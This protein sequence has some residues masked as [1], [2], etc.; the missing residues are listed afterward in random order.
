MSYYK[1]TLE[2][3]FE[4]SFYRSL[5][6]PPVSDKYGADLIIRITLDDMSLLDSF[7]MALPIKV[8]CL[9]ISQVIK[10]YIVG[11]TV[12]ERN[13]L[14]NRLLIYP[15]P[16]LS[17]IQD[18][19]TDIFTAG[20]VNIQYHINNG[21]TNVQPDDPL[22]IHEQLQVTN[23]YIYKLI[24]IVLEVHYR[25]NLTESQKNVMLDDFRQVFILYAIDKFGY[26][27]DFENMN[28]QIAEMMLALL[29]KLS[30]DDFSLIQI[31]GDD[32]S[33]PTI[34]YKGYDLLDSIIDEAEFYIS[35]Y[36]I[37]GDVCIKGFK[38]ILFYTGYGDNLI[39]PVFIREGIDPYRAIFLSALYLGNMDEI[40]SNLNRLSSEEIFSE[41]FRLIAISQTEKDVSPEFL[42]MIIAEGKKKIS[43]QRLSEDWIRITE[44]I[45]QRMKL[46]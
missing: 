20:N 19:L 39:I 24:D 42:D 7:Y 34:F 45:K 32:W 21:E 17:D 46:L 30:S 3:S 2:E 14:K 41:L 11:E 44:N 29:K 35:N 18:I 8:E 43:E 10:E 12:E 31:N 27:P 4:Y 16:D 26:S 13:E 22:Y 40:F 36:D 38:D 25:V 15:N 1:K 33:H 37:F 6:F 23:D 5:G 9:T 28:P